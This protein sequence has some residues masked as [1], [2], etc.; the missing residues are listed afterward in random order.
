MIT[1]CEKKD[2]PAPFEKLTAW[3]DNF[4]TE[5]V[6]WSPYHLE[7]EMPDGIR[8][9][10]RV[11]F[12]EIVAGLDYDVSGKIVA[13]ERSEDA[14]SFTFV[15]DKKSAKIVFEGERTPSGCRFTHTESFGLMKPVIGPV[16]NFL[17][18]KVFHRK[19]ANWQLIRDDMVLDNDY[20]YDILTEGK[21]PDRIPVEELKK[22]RQ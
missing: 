15:S 1:L 21:Y 13:C 8:E 22:E 3:A 10:A 14:F 4:E 16:V 19:K 18:F 17:I 11:R 12:R 2:I 6:K 7:C 9:G 20:L 5:F